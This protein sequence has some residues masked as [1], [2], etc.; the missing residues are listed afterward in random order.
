MPSNDTGSSWTEK[1]Y[2]IAVRYKY[3]TCAKCGNHFPASVD[4]PLS[5]RPSWEHVNICNPC[6]PEWAFEQKRYMNRP[7]KEPGWRPKP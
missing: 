5:F 6:K 2:G 7:Y 1:D 4:G 3:F